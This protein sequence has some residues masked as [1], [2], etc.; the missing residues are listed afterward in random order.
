MTISFCSLRDKHGLFTPFKKHHFL[1]HLRDPRVYMDAI[2]YDRTFYN[3]DLYKQGMIVC[4]KKAVEQIKR[5]FGRCK[6]DTK[7]KI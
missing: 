3:L 7:R 4:L 6:D 5:E 1:Q 2:E